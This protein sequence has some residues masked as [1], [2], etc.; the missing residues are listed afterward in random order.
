MNRKAYI[1]KKIEFYRE[2]SRLNPIIESV[3]HCLTKKI[4]TMRLDLSEYSPST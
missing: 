2:C 4:N 1:G 3:K